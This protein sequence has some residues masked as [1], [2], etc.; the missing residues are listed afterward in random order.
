MAA[1]TLLAAAAVSAGPDGERAAA[2]TEPTLRELVG[3]RLVVSMRGTTPSR[4]LLGRIRRGEIGGVILF[5]G[6]VAS[7][8]QL[9]SLTASL[10]AAARAGGRPPLLV[11][12]DQEGG[13]IR[14]LPWAGPAA[15]TADLGRG[16]PAE[17][18]RAARAAGTAL[19]AAGVNVDLAPVLDVPVRGSFMAAEERT[20]SSSPAR[21][22]LLGTAFAT[23]LADAGVAATAK[24]FPG[25]G[26]AVRSTDRSAVT[27]TPTGAALERDLAPFRRAVAAGVPVM[28]LSNASYI[29]FGPAPAAWSAPIQSLLRQELGFRGVTI[30]DAL[31]PAAATRGRTL[32]AAALL[33]V[34]AGVDLVLLT[35]SEASSDGVFRALLE[36]AADGEISRASLHRSNDRILALKER[37]G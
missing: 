6:N 34:R 33:A 23:G 26:R 8:P 27:L 28:M 25:I 5:G 19:R 18:R 16:T 20:F 14:R 13:E 21:V 3:Q 29:A 31:D 32:P 1:V 2:A 9:R 7:A 30:T 17:A 4:T 12:V 11:A 37:V 35:G 24:H 36:R 10:Q 15:S 22:G